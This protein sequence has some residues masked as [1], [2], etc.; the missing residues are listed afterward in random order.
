MGFP[1]SMGGDWIDYLVSD[2]IASPPHLLEGSFVEKILW[3]PHSYFCN[4]HRQACNGPH[5]GIVPPEAIS[6]HWA[7]AAEH[8]EHPPLASAEHY[9][10]SGGHSVFRLRE[11]LRAKYELPPFATVY[12]CFN[13][14]CLTPTFPPTCHMAIFHKDHTAMSSPI[15]RAALQ[16]R[17]AHLPL[18]V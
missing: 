4:D 10:R 18:L 8:P 13:Q 1:G 14:A 16:A 6:A 5:C 3:M 11:V 12:C 7:A 9:E 15:S 2:T 17:A